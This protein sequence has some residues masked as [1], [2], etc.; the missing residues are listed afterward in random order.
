MAE[1][2]SKYISYKE[3]TKSNTAIK[4]GIHNVPNPDQWAAM[5]KLGTEVFDKVRE[6]FGKPLYVSSFFR[7]EE[8]NA[9][10]G[11]SKTSQHCKGEAIDIDA[12]VFGGVTNKEIFDY[13]KENLDYDQLINEFDYSWIHVSFVSTE[14]NRKRCLSATKNRQGRTVYSVID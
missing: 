10:I 12:D 7:S 1:R 14:K 6:H 9:K 11:G 13:I 3:A 2:V 5:Q 8:L 4:Y